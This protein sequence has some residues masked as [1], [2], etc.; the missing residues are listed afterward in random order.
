MP[1][2]QVAEADHHRGDHQGHPAP[3]RNFS[4]TVMVRMV[5]Q[6]TSPTRWTERWRIHCGS[7]CRSLDEKL[8]HPQLGEGKG[9]EDVDGVHD[10]QGRNRAVGV[11]QQGNGGDAHEENAVAH[12]Q[13]DRQ[14][15]EAVRQ[16]GVD[17][18]VGHD[19]RSVDK[20]GLGRHQQ[21][22]AFGEDGDEG[23]PV[24]HRPV[25]EQAVGQHG[26][27]GLPLHRLDPHQRIAENSTPAVKASEVA[28]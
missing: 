1:L 23:N 13:A 3:F 14:G 9:D 4:N 2:D 5:T 15:G 17:G 10:H 6:S 28:M 21:Q 25:A 7:S 11:E 27:E 16:P 24:P 8:R 20:A 22:G 26:I 12:G 18:H 19:P